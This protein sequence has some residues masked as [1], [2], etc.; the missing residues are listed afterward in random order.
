MRANS[1]WKLN[2]PHTH[3]F[4]AIIKF[5]FIDGLYLTLYPDDT[6]HLENSL[7]Y[8]SLTYT[9]HQQHIYP[10]HPTNTQK[11]SRNPYHP[12]HIHQN[13]TTLN[14]TLTITS[15]ITA[16]M[17]GNILNAESYPYYVLT[18][19]LIQKQIISHLEYDLCQSRFCLD[20][21]IAI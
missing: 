13:T 18:Q 4:P 1:I 19:Y 9:V 10:I 2:P 21:E 11:Y 6:L 5:Q 14:S 17:D 20:F 3:I 7:G 8:S 12:Q 16:V 15:H